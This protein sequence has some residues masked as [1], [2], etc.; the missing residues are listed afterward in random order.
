MGLLANLDGLAIVYPLEVDKI[1]AADGTFRTDLSPQHMASILRIDPRPISANA[2][3]HEIAADATLFKAVVCTLTDE[4]KAFIR[5]FRKSQQRKGLPP[6]GGGGEFTRK[7]IAFT[8][9]DIG[10]PDDQRK[11]ILT[12]ISRAARGVMPVGGEQ[13]RA[14]GIARGDIESGSFGLWAG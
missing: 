11:M 4:S 10:N 6:N 5:E 14:V 9:N 1:V 12:A 3:E 2:S 13:A 8:L 7:E